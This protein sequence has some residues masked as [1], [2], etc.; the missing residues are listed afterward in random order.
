MEDYAC[1]VI[2]EMIIV[3]KEKLSN[4]DK[5]ERPIYAGVIEDLKTMLVDLVH[6]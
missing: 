2:K 5:M 1:Q 4:A 6:H 3:Y